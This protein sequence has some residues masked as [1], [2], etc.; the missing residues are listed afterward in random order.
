[1]KSLFLFNEV[2]CVS[3]GRLP[4]P[5]VMQGEIRQVVLKC[6]KC[7]LSRGLGC[8]TSLRISNATGADHLFFP[9][10]ENC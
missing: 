4:V 1:M 2:G 6:P 3:G 10:Q 5:L 8:G 7:I 9:W